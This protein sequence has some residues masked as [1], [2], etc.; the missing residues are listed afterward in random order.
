MASIDSLPR[1]YGQGYFGEGKATHST[2]KH[3]PHH[4]IGETRG[5]LP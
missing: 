1:C 3:D 2:S 4:Y 5:L